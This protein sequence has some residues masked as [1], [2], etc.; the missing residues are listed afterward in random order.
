M[1]ERARKTLVNAAKYGVVAVAL[2]FLLW[3]GRLD[4]SHFRL[5]EGGL[6]PLAWA[7]LA[8]L[9]Q[10]LLSLLRYGVL[11]RAAVVR[12]PYAEIFRIG[13]I[14]DF[15][16]SV[17]FGGLGGDL[18]KVIY[19]T[20][21]G[22]SRSGSLACVF[23]DRLVGLVA[24]LALCGAALLANAELVMATPAL[25]SMSTFTLLL[26]GG[27]VLSCVVGLAA[28]ARGRGVGLAVWAALSLL[29]GASA[30]LTGAGANPELPRLA[31]LPLALGLAVALAAPSLLPG[32]TLDRLVSR[33]LPF[34]D[35]IMSLIQSVLLYREHLGAVGAMFV[36]SL[37]LQVLILLSLYWLAQAM[38]MPNPPEFVQVL[39][40][41]PVAFLSSSLPLPGG[42]L[43][44]GEF[45]FDQ[46]LRNC[47]VGGQPVLGGAEIFL[48]WRV[49]SVLL[50]L[51]GLPWY[52][53]DAPNKR[54][55][56]EILEE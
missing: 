12:M 51:I 43:G 7:S 35:K 14:A 44:V 17:F 36:F 6:A 54:E 49:L 5:R 47:L 55:L 38:P 41:A 10:Y 53:R 37:F 46:V 4:F 29:V 28:L 40:A 27:F 31:G 32:R 30:L 2:G 39:F 34:G 9:A 24:L 21:A 19:V 20:R 25:R 15:F 13:M 45:A 48:S 3:S 42:G 16:N 1:T 11:L 23:M 33:H 18:V 22:G 56:E 50:G 52:L 26:F 8:M